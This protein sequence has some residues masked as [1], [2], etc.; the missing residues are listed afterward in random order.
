MSGILLHNRACIT[1]GKTTQGQFTAAVTDSL[2]PNGLLWLLMFVGVSAKVS[3][4]GDIK[5]LVCRCHTCINVLLYVYLHLPRVKCITVD[6]M[7][8]NTTDLRRFFSISS[9]PYS[10]F[11]ETNTETSERRTARFRNSMDTGGGGDRHTGQWG[12]DDSDVREDLSHRTH[13]CSW[14]TEVGRTSA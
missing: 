12:G 13:V 11:L 1:L 4:R 5:F 7:K 8:Q 6:N 10:R 14:L 9:D 3:L 2:P